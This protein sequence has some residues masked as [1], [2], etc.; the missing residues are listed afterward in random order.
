[1]KAGEAAQQRAGSEVHPLKVQQN[2][3]VPQLDESHQA[4]TELRSFL[5]VVLHLDAEA[6]HDDHLA[7]MTDQ[8]SRPDLEFPLSVRPPACRVHMVGAFGRCL[9]RV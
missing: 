3:H 9:R 5:I 2:P 6:L 7:H 8:Q 1:M 4:R